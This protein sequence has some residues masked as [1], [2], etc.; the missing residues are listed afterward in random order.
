MDNAIE[1]FGDEYREINAEHGT[2]GSK[3][4]HPG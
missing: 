1:Q 4:E 2:F 3:V